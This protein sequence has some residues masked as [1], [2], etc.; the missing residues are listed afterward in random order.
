M[1]AEEVRIRLHNTF[2]DYAEQAEHN[3]EWERACAFRLAADLALATVV[4]LTERE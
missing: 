2:K 3:R 1:T 4:T